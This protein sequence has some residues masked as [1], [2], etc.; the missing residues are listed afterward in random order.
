MPPSADEANGRQGDWR[1]GGQRGKGGGIPLAQMDS[2]F[3]SAGAKYS[4]SSFPAGGDERR[5]GL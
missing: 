4:M 3:A 2:K 1:D 5:I